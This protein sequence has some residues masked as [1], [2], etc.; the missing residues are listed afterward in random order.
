A[1]VSFR[2]GPGR[3]AAAHGPRTC[4]ASLFRFFEAVVWAVARTQIVVAALV[5]RFPFHFPIG[6]RGKSG[7]WTGH[8]S[9]IR[10]FNRRRMVWSSHMPIAKRTQKR[11]IIPADLHGIL[12]IVGSAVSAEWADRR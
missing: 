12:K 4:C 6:K 7:K 10:D 9:L 2:Y 11:A 3:S 1:R 5:R 8:S